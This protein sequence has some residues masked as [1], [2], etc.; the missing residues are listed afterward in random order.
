MISIDQ[1]N[2][3]LKELIA[4]MASYIPNAKQGLPHEVFLFISSLT[5]MV[6]VELIIK[7][8]QRQTLLVWRHDEF[9]HG[10]H[11]PGGILR[12][13]EK[14][15]DRIAA[16][17]KS[18]LG[19]TVD[20]NVAPLKLFERTVE[21]R[22]VRGHFIS[23]LYKCQLLSPPD[24]QIKCTDISAPVPGQWMWHTGCPEKLIKPHEI[25]REYIEA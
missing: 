16:V 25:F 7:N 4:K 8:E 18:E 9:Y 2:S 1:K 3:D 13:K 24:A 15:S 21:H 23:L 10:W 14:F 19:A 6:N 17:A 11:L 22:D 12:F 20:T 5:P